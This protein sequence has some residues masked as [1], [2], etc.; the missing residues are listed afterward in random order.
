MVVMTESWNEQRLDDLNGRVDSGFT[1]LR[2]EIKAG[3][4]QLRVEITQLR[5][6]MQAGDAQLRAE[7]GEGFAGVRGEF[8][9]LQRTLLQV[10]GGLIGT[11]IASTTAIVI[12]I[13]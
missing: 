10:G 1:E 13:S 6:E 9:A 12:A 8:T 4:A 3:D 7:M 5:A 2:A 11:V